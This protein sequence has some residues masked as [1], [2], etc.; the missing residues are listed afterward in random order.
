MSFLQKISTDRMISIDSYYN[1]Y[2]VELSLDTDVDG[3]TYTLFDNKGMQ[4]KLSEWTP[5]IADVKVGRYNN[6]RNIIKAF[7]VACIVSAVAV[8]VFAELPALAAIAGVSFIVS[9]VA[10]AVLRLV[11]LKA[12]E[13]AF[14]QQKVIQLKKD[15]DTRFTNLEQFKKAYPCVFEDHEDATPTLYAVNLDGVQF[16]KFVADNGL[17]DGRI[18]GKVIEYFAATQFS[19]TLLSKKMELRIEICDFMPTF[20]GET[21][22]AQRQASRDQRNKERDQGDIVPAE[23]SPEPAP[24]DSII[25]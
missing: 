14:F 1:D 16:A 7:E 2:M 6:I 17:A 20:L 23:V 3:G 21:L 25:L 10:I 15:W 18:K 12:Y 5:E 4:H 19:Q 24:E 13:K 11:S 9:L 22:T 8:F